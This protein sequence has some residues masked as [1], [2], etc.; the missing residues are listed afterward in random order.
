MTPRY[1]IFKCNP[2][3]DI[4]SSATALWVAQSTSYTYGG[5]A[6]LPGVELRAAQTNSRVHRLTFNKVA[7]A[8]SYVLCGSNA[9]P[10]YARQVREM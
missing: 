7:G 2:A 9:D 3:Y 10:L 6:S 5:G 1:P 4:R 8:G